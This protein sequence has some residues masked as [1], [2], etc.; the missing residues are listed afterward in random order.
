MTS[1]RPMAF[2]F[3]S[4]RENVELLTQR[5]SALTTERQTLRAN[6]ASETPLEQNRVQIARAQWELSYALI[7]RY[8]PNPAEQAA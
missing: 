3:H 6:G 4:P 8:L 7:E 5:I 1:L 2:G